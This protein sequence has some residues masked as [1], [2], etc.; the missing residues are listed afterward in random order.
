[1]VFFLI[2]D[3]GSNFFIYCSLG[4]KEWRKHVFVDESFNPR[5]M[6]FLKGKL[7]IMGMCGSLLEIAISTIDSDDDE[8]VTLKMSEVIPTDNNVRAIRVSGSLAYSCQSVVMESFGEVFKIDR[9]HIP[10][11]VYQNFLTSIDIAKLDFS[12]MAWEEVNSLDDYVFFLGDNN[13]LS[14]LASELGLPRGC[15][16][17]TQDGEISLY[18]YDLEDKSVSQCLP[19]PDIPTPWSSPEWLMISTAT[20]RVDDFRRTR[21][22]V[23]GKEAEIATRATVTS[24]DKDADIEHIG[25]ARPS[26]MDNDDMVRLI[27]DRLHMVDYIHLRAVSKKYRSMLNL[28]RSS[29]RT[30]RTTGLSP[31]LV[32]AKYDQHVYNFVSPMHNNE[33]YLVN[34]PEL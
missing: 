18:R 32:F 23:L 6:F 19:C 21:N 29:S 25:E 26:F 8:Q 14:C 20:P 5:S 22:H 10:R 34:I 13:Q 2:G 33:N 30:V 3:D 15:V 28:K 1:M 11:G 4:D 7:F 24:V 27:S 9:Y 12:S 17:F 16:Y 31:W